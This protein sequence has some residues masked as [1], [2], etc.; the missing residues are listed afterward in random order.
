VKTTQPRT[1]SVVPKFRQS[2]EPLLLARPT[3]VEDLTPDLEACNWLRMASPSRL[4]VSCFK[5][6]SSR[7]RQHSDRPPSPASTN[8]C[9]EF[10]SGSRLILLPNDW[11]AASQMARSKT[12]VAGRR[13]REL[14]KQIRRLLKRR[15]GLAG[16][17]HALSMAAGSR[18]N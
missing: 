10:L 15:V 4:W 1:P 11:A 2:L 17:C 9:S 18:R 13:G 6:G 5:R 8:A 14:A 3:L 7:W 16:L 12:T